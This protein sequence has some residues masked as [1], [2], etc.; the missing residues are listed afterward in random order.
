MMVRDR[1]RTKH[2]SNMG[3][4]LRVSNYNEIDTLIKAFTGIEKLLL[5]SAPALDNVERLSLQYNAVMAA[6]IAEVKH[7]FL[8]SIADA[9]KRIFGLKD[10][11][12]ATE[13]M[14]RAVDIPFSFMRN[15]VYID[16][17]TRDLKYAIEK[18]ELVS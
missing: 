1:K 10:V 15:S 18:G 13:Y 2:L 4:E 6:K 7:I 14:V 5:V 16:E 11:D 8:V 12:R 3:V 17:I 9:E